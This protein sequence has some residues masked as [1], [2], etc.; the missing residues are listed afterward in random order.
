[1]LNTIKKIV[2][3]K[4]EYRENMARVA[5]LPEEYQFVFEEM[6]RYMW[7]F[8]GGNGLDMLKVQYDLIELFEESAAQGR[9]VLD[10]T[11]KDV[12]GFCDELIQDTEKWTDSPRKKLNRTMTKKFSKK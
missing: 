5:A 7:S 2:D 1:M 9:P 12:A 4:K 11:G 10:V 3:D 6:Q 8:A